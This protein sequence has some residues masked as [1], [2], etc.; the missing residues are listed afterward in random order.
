MT[1]PA[2]AP[3][4]LLRRDDPPE[5]PARLALGGRLELAQAATLWAGLGA[6]LARPAPRGL[7]VDLAGVEV[8][9]GAAA[10]MLAHAAEAARCA[11]GEVRFTGAA[12]DVAELLAWHARAGRPCL[13]P[14]PAGEPILTHVGRATLAIGRETREGLDF[15]GQAVRA[16]TAAV[17]F[18]RTVNWR[19]AAAV[20]ERAGADGVPIVVSIAFLT[21]MI[22]AFQ[23]AMQLKQFGA[24]I[25]TADLVGISMTRELAPLMTAIIVAGRS[26]AA[27]AAELGTMRVSEE[28]DALRTLGLCPYRYLVFPRVAALVVAMPLLAALADLVAV[29][30]GLFVALLTL[31]LT[32]RAYLVQTQQAIDPVDVVS[33]LLKA[34]VFGLIVALIACERGLH[35]R[36][37]AE[38][39]GR[40][41][42]SAVVTCLFAIVAVD[43]VFAVLFHVYGV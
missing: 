18:P 33:G 11:G 5:G 23:S 28:V 32:G 26:G 43:A 9:D 39:V 10:A 14:A 40:A 29:A 20:L 16:A 42:T 25:F 1:E 15:L 19:D 7:E 38:G 34:G 13:R 22:M 2:P 30:G 36:G 24:E 21:G 8:L 31:D 35:A 17:R 6:A 3:P 27:F 37:G 41:T 4:F 12:P